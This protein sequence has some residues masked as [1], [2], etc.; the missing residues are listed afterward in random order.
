MTP[1]PEFVNRW[2]TR[3]L[4][5]VVAAA[6]EAGLDLTDTHGVLDASVRSRIDTHGAP[7]N[8]M[9]SLFDELLKHGAATEDA[10]LLRTL[11]LF[12]QMRPRVE[13][14][15]RAYQALRGRTAAAQL[16]DALAGIPPELIRAGREGR[17]VFI[18]GP[19]LGVLSSDGLLSDLVDR[20]EREALGAVINRDL[21]DDRVGVQNLLR[22]RLTR[23]Q[24]RVFIRELLAEA[25]SGLHAPHDELTALAEIPD[26]T[27]ITVNADHLLER[28]RGGET[29]GV[30]A[31]EFT[32]SS[33]HARLFKT[34][35][36]LAHPDSVHD[37]PLGPWLAIGEGLLAWEDLLREWLQTRA[38]LM[39]GFA[40]PE[41]EDVLSELQRLQPGSDLPVWVLPLKPTLKDG[42]STDRVIDLKHENHAL[43]WIGR[44]ADRIEIERTRSRLIV[45]EH[46]RDAYAEELESDLQDR[47]RSARTLAD[48]GRHEEAMARFT[49]LL[50]EVERRLEHDAS[51]RWRRWRVQ[52]R[53]DI[54]VCQL[55]LEREDD[56]Q[57]GLAALTNEDLT[58]APPDVRAVAAE[59][60]A[61]TNDMERARAFLPLG[62]GEDP[63]IRAARWR[64]SIRMG[65]V[66]DGDVPEEPLVRL[67]LALHELQRGRLDHAV[68]LA[69]PHTQSHNLNVVLEAVSVVAG[70]L[71]R[72]LFD[73]AEIRSSLPSD[74]VVRRRY[75]DAVDAAMQ[76]LRCAPNRRH[77]FRGWLLA[78]YASWAAVALHPSQRDTALQELRGVVSEDDFVIQTEIFEL[79]AVAH[80]LRA[81]GSLGALDDL[82]AT[83]IPWRD[84]HRRAAVL[85]MAGRIDEA[86]EFLRDVVREHPGHPPLD[87]LYAQI[88]LRRGSVAEAS[89]VARR[90]YELFPSKLH[91]AL[92]GRVLREAERW[93]DA[94]E[95]VDSLRDEPVLEWLQLRAEVATRARPEES[96]E[97]WRAC[98][99]LA[100][101]DVTLVWNQAFSLLRLGDARAADV[102]WE[103]LDLPG[104]RALTVDD[105]WRIEQMVRSGSPETIAP[106]LE[107]LAKLL[108]QDF[109]DDPDA[110]ALR[111]ML[112][113][114]LR[115]PA[116]HREPKRDLIQAS[117]MV[118]VLPDEEA[119]ARLTRLR[120]LRDAEWNLYSS[121]RLDFA[122]LCRLGGARAPRI[123]V[124]MLDGIENAQPLLNAPVR[125]FHRRWT[126]SLSGRKVLVSELELDLLE[127]F[128]LLRSFAEL[129]QPGGALVLF[130][131]VHQDVLQSALLLQ[132]SRRDD[133]LREIEAFERALTHHLVARSGGDDRANDAQWARLRD[134]A[135][136]TASDGP[137]AE[138]VT[139]VSARSVIERLRAELTT[140]E[141]RALER[142][143]PGENR[144]RTGFRESP[145]RAV[146][147][148][149]VLRAFHDAGVLRLLRELF[150]D[151]LE[152]GP[153]GVRQLHG[154]REAARGSVDA[155]VL[156]DRVHRTLGALLVE[157]RVEIIERPEVLVPEVYTTK[158]NEEMAEALARAPL[159]EALS[160]REALTE[161]SRLLLTMDGVIADPMMNVEAL[162]VLRWPSGDALKARVDL[163]RQTDARVIDL[164]DVL[165]RLVSGEREFSLRVGLA[166][167]GV[168]EAL[169]PETI[170]EFATRHGRLDSARVRRVLDAVERPARAGDGGIRGH[171]EA[172]RAR[173]HLAELYVRA[174]EAICRSPGSEVNER[175]VM[176]APLL[177]RLE[178]LDGPE[179]SVTIARFAQFLVLRA[180]DRL[181]DWFAPSPEGED[182]YTIREGTPGGLV[183]ES[184]R[185]WCEGHSLRT[186]GVNRGLRSAFLLVD[187]RSSDG[188][189]LPAAAVIARIVGE[190]VQEKGL[191]S[192]GEGAIGTLTLVSGGWSNR[193]GA[194][195]GLSFENSRTGEA[196][197]LT[198]ED[199]L[200]GCAQSLADGR[201]VLRRTAISVRV[202][203]PLPDTLGVLRVQALPE[204]LLLRAPPAKISLHARGLAAAVSALD[205]RLREA[206]ER[207]AAAPEEPETRR[208]LA[209]AAATPWRLATEYPEIFSSWG[210]QPTLD[211]GLPEGAD[212]LRQLLSEP[213]GP[214]PEGHI[215]TL[216]HDR[217][218]E[219]G[220]W[221]S[222]PSP[223]D[224]VEDVY[225]LPGDLAVQ[226]AAV[227]RQYDGLSRRIEEAL[228]RL[229][230]PDDQPIGL[231][232]ADLVFLSWTARKERM[233]VLSGAS[234]DLQKR[235][236]S[237]W[238]RAIRTSLPQEPPENDP[239]SPAWEIRSEAVPSSSLACHE[240]ALL[241]VCRSIVS[242]TAPR[243]SFRHD[244]LWLTWRLYGWVVSLA[245][246]MEPHTRRRWIE[247]I[248]R[249]FVEG[250]V[251]PP[252]ADRLDPATFAV[253]P[254]R[255]AV[256]LYSLLLSEEISR[257]T[258]APSVESAEPF[259]VSSEL[260]ALLVELASRELTDGER[261]PRSDSLEQSALGWRA[262]TTI[263]ELAM[264]ALLSLDLKGFLRLPAARRLRWILDL[265]RPS[266]AVAKLHPTLVDR[267]MVA[268]I[269][270]ARELTR[271]EQIA[272]GEVLDHLH[273]ND[274][275]TRLWKMFG[276]VAL[277]LAGHSERALALRESLCRHT[278]DAHAA[279]VF[280]MLLL[281]IT[282]DAAGI[283][284]P[285]VETMIGAANACEDDPIPFALAPTRLILEGAP[286]QVEAAKN[287]LAGLRARFPDDRVK[288]ALAALKIE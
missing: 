283:L 165:P 244:A 74:F 35:G 164:C 224:F 269:M 219:S 166:S 86:A 221:H 36:D 119:I 259:V 141:L 106:R 246:R 9:R 225:A 127:H 226:L 287:W 126:E 249:G 217:W 103:S 178:A 89:T 11:G 92:L 112:L 30:R 198:Y 23:A 2:T 251:A 173:I 110:E 4:R 118:E 73:D 109:P 88:A 232:C 77:A 39:V 122:S 222:L 105:L 149:A 42:L 140:G 233:V 192:F 107:R 223:A 19:Q 83:G 78:E 64:I 159:R 190:P 194:F 51:P 238:L 90:A 138:G 46:Q 180:V 154:E 202:Q 124:G 158:E 121:G 43:A 22:K 207:F 279:D 218:R 48:E 241:M 250:P 63:R 240:R 196:V 191:V 203:Y 155:A 8:R 156:A 179:D 13:Q 59:L 270:N 278:S 40:N 153:E 256:L 7:I 150:S 274:A 3:W 115:F 181:K 142:R 134:A 24:R 56:V 95:A 125:T 5:Q 25:E 288:S 169:R 206:L 210:A 239:I 17:L 235:L 55:N 184:L 161:P 257:E 145:R 27:S 44:L 94:W 15:R 47:R 188:P 37:L 168:L 76:R 21:R 61:L 104:R 147:D 87:Y 57:R 93:S 108:E 227:R 237:L 18:V 200:I 201:D 167:M 151:G 229:D 69:L 65:K 6:V 79:D 10:P 261:E 117:S 53:V 139:R 163:V 277:V 262:P 243:A 50:Q 171:V 212:E 71:N 186:R 253:W 1:S 286:E 96:V 45:V 263:P 101:S 98:R 113:A 132:R 199:L 136:L 144:V 157:R 58:E 54:V 52:C 31:H 208:E 38:W 205:G 34:R 82:K 128:D 255:L 162:Q 258:T 185:A 32:P 177:D 12:V 172:M 41:A 195:S 260:D 137:L 160:W 60:F 176:V 182:H 209:R 189:S 152:L 272:L 97:A 81:G 114:E 146:A 130:E 170:A 143:F 245:Q 67:D 215:P 174:S 123:M 49:A 85:F 70:A 187:R 266:S 28:A 102:I 265:P 29:A 84:A 285:E 248:A 214:L 284:A 213:R 273:E 183:W 276:A 120:A 247:D 236:P 252:D 254:H 230:R 267:V 280:G 211:V 231:L 72:T 68:D 16:G 281:A 264:R 271:E 62:D 33:R 234:I 129:L 26:A 228:D 131:D 242:R 116:G 148:V 175:S 193:P 204:A 268:A 75:V 220:P 216:V 197:K 133:Q 14:L 275:Q 91:R 282:R 111:Y 100:P 80:A 66:P 135:W 99:A 20:L